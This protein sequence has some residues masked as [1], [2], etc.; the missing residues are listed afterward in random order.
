VKKNIR[1]E[2]LRALNKCGTFLLPQTTLFSHV[3]LTVDPEPTPDEMKDVLRAMNDEGL[4][5]AGRNPLGDPMWKL[6]AAGHATA[7]ELKL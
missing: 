4:I 3:L 5:V 2:I 7:T 6:T 1:L